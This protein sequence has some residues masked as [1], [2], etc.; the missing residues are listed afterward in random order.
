M[1]L[2]VD[3]HPQGAFK[4]QANLRKTCRKSGVVAFAL[5]QVGV[6][7]RVQI[8]PAQGTH[9][10]HQHEQSGKP[11]KGSDLLES[12]Y[13]LTHGSGKDLYI[14]VDELSHNQQRGSPF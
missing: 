12:Q 14:Q 9:T 1:E 10:G 3:F 6:I 5:L 13:L 2:P 4:G 11:D 7:D 8:G